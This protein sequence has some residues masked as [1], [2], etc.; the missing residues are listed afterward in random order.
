[1]STCFS[2][3]IKNLI[4]RGKAGIGTSPYFILYIDYVIGYLPPYSFVTK[5]ILPMLNSD[6]CI[7]L[8][9]LLH[10]SNVIL[11]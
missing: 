3:L 2:R 8:P 7:V 5:C 10:A 4:D 6:I 1:M 9:L 11:K